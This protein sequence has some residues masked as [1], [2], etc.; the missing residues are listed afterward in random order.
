MQKEYEVY[1]IIFYRSATGVEEL[2]VKTHTSAIDD[3]AEAYRHAANLIDNG[4]RIEIQEVTRR[5]IA[6]TDRKLTLPQE[7]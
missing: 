6:C 7:A 4:E 5:V 3:Y 2:K 1:Q